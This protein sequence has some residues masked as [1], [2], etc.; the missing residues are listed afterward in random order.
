[1]N[2]K[3]AESN[4]T[5]DESKKNDSDAPNRATGSPAEESI[6]MQDALILFADK[7]KD[8]S[9]SP[10]HTRNSS[11]RFFTDA[12]PTCRYCR[13]E[14]ERPSELCLLVLKKA[15]TEAK[16]SPSQKEWPRRA[17]PRQRAWTSF[18]SP[19]RC[20]IALLA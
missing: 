10:M 4:R 2:M 6:D 12:Y 9:N 16:H 18:H 14:A 17:L 7:R 20:R 19:F 15:W 11:S 1:M 8:T 13:L 5:N 3:T